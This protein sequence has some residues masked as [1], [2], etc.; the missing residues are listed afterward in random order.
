MTISVIFPSLWRSLLGL[1]EVR[2]NLEAKDVRGTIDQLLAS[3]PQLRDEILD[4]QGNVEHHLLF[5]LN[6]ENV[7]RLDG[8][9]TPVRD[10][11]R[12]A[13]LLAVAG[14]SLFLSPLIRWCVWGTS[15]I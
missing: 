15:V 10:G 13:I 6:D 5:F 12:F 1:R 7:A 11:D 14:G 4:D 3:F 9:N 8:L 2:I